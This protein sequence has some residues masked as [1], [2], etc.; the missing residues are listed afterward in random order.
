MMPELTH[1]TLNQSISHT[2]YWKRPISILSMS[3]YV[4]YVFLEKMAKL[5][6]S[7]RDTDQIPNYVSSDQ[8]LHCLPVT[9]WG[10]PD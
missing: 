9:N 3:G 6:A 7:N 5:F 1:F 8:G 10:S 2:I 4:I